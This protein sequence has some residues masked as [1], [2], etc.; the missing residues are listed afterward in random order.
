VWTSRF[1]PLLTSAQSK[2][3]SLPQRHLVDIGISRINLNIIAKEKRNSVEA[4]RTVTIDESDNP[5]AYLYNINF[6][7][8]SLF[9]QNSETMRFSD[10][11]DCIIDSR[12]YFYR[13]LPN[14]LTKFSIDILK[15][16]YRNLSLLMLL[17]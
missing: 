9:N 8:K 2:L 17:I 4:I 15:K 12:I 5:N 16:I 14:F 6:N 1:H 13:G 3:D 10:L 7:V 11:R